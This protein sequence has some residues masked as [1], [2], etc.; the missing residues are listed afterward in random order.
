MI[1]RALFFTFLVLIINSTY[2]QTAITLEDYFR[3]LKSVKVET[4]SKSYDFLFDTGGGLTLISPS[5][6]KDIKKAVYGN[7]VGFRMDGEKI[8][9]KICDSV[10]LR[11]GGIN[12]FHS[13]VGVFDIM[14]LLPEGFK[15]VDGL[16]SL[17]T[18]ENE[19]ISL[20]LKES[21]LIVETE[22]SFNKKIKNMKL[23]KSQF[24]NGPTGRE[25]NIF[26]GFNFKKHDW[27]FLFDTGNISKT[28]ISENTAKEWGIS[29]KNEGESSEIE[30]FIFEMAGDSISAPAKIDEI[31]YDGA[32][33]YDFIQQSEF[34]ISFKDQKIWKSIS[35]Q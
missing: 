27:W 11:I 10:Y 30:E 20:N 28:V 24:A 14:S 6:V 12:F 34:S 1:K 22:K 18:F 7:F 33:S 3:S 16:I 4:G 13:Y 5:I 26:T 17:K 15:R 32:L 21:K 19:K 35:Q 23:V 31:I 25:L 8:E 2:S 9:T 29:P